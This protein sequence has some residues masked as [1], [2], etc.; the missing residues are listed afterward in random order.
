MIQQSR[1]IALHLGFSE[2]Y[3]FLHCVDPLVSSVWDLQQLR[4]VAESANPLK[5]NCA[6][7]SGNY[8]ALGGDSLVVESLRTG[9]GEA[10]VDTS[11]MKRLANVKVALVGEE[12]VGKSTLAAALTSGFS[13][14]QTRTIG[15]WI[16]RMNNLESARYADI[17]KNM[18]LW[19]CGGQV[20][21]GNV[22]QVFLKNTSLVLLVTT[23]HRE[24]N[25][26]N[27]KYWLN[28]V[29]AATVRKPIV[30]LVI[31]MIDLP[32]KV[33]TEE[34]I[35]QFAAENGI[36]RVI[37]T[38]AIGGR[39][40][41]SNSSEIVEVPEWVA[42]VDEL[43]DAMIDAVD[44]EQAV[45]QIRFPLF[46]D[47]MADVEAL[48]GMH[49]IQE[50]KRVYENL[51]PK[52][53]QRPKFDEV[54]L[55]M[56]L[57]AMDAEGRIF[58]SNSS[59]QY[60]F[61]D[62]QMLHII[63]STIINKIATENS[64]F[65]SLDDVHKLMREHTGVDDIRFAQHILEVTESIKLCV[66]IEGE[67]RYFF[68]TSLRQLSKQLTPEQVEL[69]MQ[70]NDWIK[71]DYQ[72]APEIIYNKIIYEVV[73]LGF[74]FDTFG[75]FEAFLREKESKN[76]C[77]IKMVDWK[78]PSVQLT[79]PEGVA[80]VLVTLQ[81]AGSSAAIYSKIMTGHFSNWFNRPEFQAKLLRND[82]VVKCDQCGLL[83]E[84]EAIQAAIEQMERDL[85]AGHD[86][87]TDR[88]TILCS[89][90]QNPI[91]VVQ[92]LSR[93]PQDAAGPVGVGINGVAINPIT[94]INPQAMEM[95]KMMEMMQ[96]M[97]EKQTSSLGKVIERESDAVKRHV[98]A[99]VSTV[100]EA[101]HEITAEMRK[102]ASYLTRNGL[103]RKTEEETTVL[104]EEI[105]AI[106]ASQERTE[107]QN[108]RILEIQQE[109]L[110]QN[111]LMATLVDQLA[112]STNEIKTKVQSLTKIVPL[113]MIPLPEE[114]G[115]LKRKGKIGIY[116]E[117]CYSEV[118][119]LHYERWKTSALKFFHYALVVGKALGVLGM[120]VTAVDA[121]FGYT[122]ELFNSSLEQLGVNLES[123]G[124]DL[125]NQIQSN[126]SKLGETFKSLAM[127]ERADNEDSVE[128]NNLI[129]DASRLRERPKERLYQTQA[130]QEELL[131]MLKSL[132]REYAK[133]K[134]QPPQLGRVIKRTSNGSWVCQRCLDLLNSNPNKAKIEVDQHNLGLD[135]M[136]PRNLP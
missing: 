101:V 124:L 39:Q 24:S 83:A 43:R 54:L 72:G 117:S 121:A 10:R 18:I 9:K 87:D 108:N 115:W 19:D 62:P 93:A 131:D 78:R 91:P 90:C 25:F 29:N 107:E 79:N 7:T 68:P 112:T 63:I 66:K 60:V 1:Q 58:L 132:D 12:Q 84:P 125:Q 126:R 102:V 65:T 81:F 86:V 49:K 30:F 22:H 37:R 92:T 26:K 11:I 15:M 44:W 40:V 114:V 109:I 64:G 95:H 111:A 103:S 128:L 85:S 52:Y 42:T 56:V 134:K 59:P 82:T 38:C 104:L 2:G 35:H 135:E 33:I 6:T 23:L 48:G 100:T 47:L 46:Y 136:E 14:N 67:N 69:L 41:S 119:T 120:A 57:E 16:H 45:G 5:L 73:R 88:Q 61:H 96:Q 106:R 77:Y 122:M 99:G 55:D 130:E 110:D 28:V 8:V 51:R 89:N 20:I 133:K 4:Q 36:T 53:L 113:F 27:L 70:R 17:E 3:K 32:G 105:R 74:Q 71:I 129:D 50:V 75:S 123:M 97:F 21:F 116:C 34:E 127:L 118:V 76:V 13:A 98:D 94:T 31:N 80:R